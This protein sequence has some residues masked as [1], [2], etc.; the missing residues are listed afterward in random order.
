MR[1]FPKVHAAS[2]ASHALQCVVVH[3][4]QMITTANILADQNHI[5]EQFG[6]RFLST[7]FK[8]H[9][10][11]FVTTDFPSFCQIKP[12]CERLPGSDA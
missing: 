8:I 3:D 10:F 11:Q 6:L 9:P 12:Q 1:G 4:G 7:L 2:H 5:A